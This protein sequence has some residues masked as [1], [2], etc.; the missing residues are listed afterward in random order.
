MEGASGAAADTARR[1]SSGGG[2]SHLGAARTSGMVAH[3]GTGAVAVEGTS[4]AVEAPGR[5]SRSSGP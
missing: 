2:G 5:G 1:R 4:G 3:L